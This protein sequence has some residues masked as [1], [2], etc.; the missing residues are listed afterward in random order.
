MERRKYI[1]F[2][3]RINTMLYCDGVA[4]EFCKTLN[5]GPD[6][7][8]LDVTQQYIPGSEIVTDI[9]TVVTQCEQKIIRMRGRVVHQQSSIVGVKFMS[10]MDIYFIVRRGRIPAT[11]AEMLL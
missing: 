9:F 11:T 4:D 2:P 6:G 1:R 5:I 10:T 7:M 3:L 8:S